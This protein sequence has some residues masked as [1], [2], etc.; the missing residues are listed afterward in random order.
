MFFFAK[1][2]AKADYDSH[3]RGALDYET[4]E[5]SLHE[6]DFGI[7]FPARS[8]TKASDLK[9]YN[10]IYDDSDYY[11]E[12]NISVQRKSNVSSGAAY[13]VSLAKNSTNDVGNNDFSRYDH[14]GLKLSSQQKERLKTID[15]AY[16]AK[17]LE[18]IMDLILPH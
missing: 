16:D 6:N 13:K 2:K 3:R 12:D 5:K 11:D 15:K 14:N 7:E 8:K 9:M 1:S 18:R 17:K 10:Y 4:D